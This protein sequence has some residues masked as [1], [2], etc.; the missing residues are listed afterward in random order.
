MVTTIQI[1]EK[2]LLLLKRL[3]EELQAKSYEEAIKKVVM[4][5][6]IKISMAG[7]LKKYLKRGESTKNIIKEVQNERRKANRF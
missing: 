2:T 3:K 1:N 4:G 5:R 6:T 7:S